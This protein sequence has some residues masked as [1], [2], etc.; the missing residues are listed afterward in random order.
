MLYSTKPKV[1]RF[2]APERSDSVAVERMMRIGVEARALKIESED[3]LFEIAV[4]SLRNDHVR[5]HS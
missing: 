4:A 5:R 3:M 1:P 2:R